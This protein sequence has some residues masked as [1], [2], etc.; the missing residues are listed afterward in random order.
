[1]RQRMGCIYKG[2]IHCKERDEYT[3]VSYTAKKGTIT[4]I[5][6]YHTLQRTERLHVYKCIIHCEERDDYMYIKVS[7]IAKN[8]MIIIRSNDKSTFLMRIIFVS[9]II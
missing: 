1:M 7:Y 4:C 2:I 6:R 8:W 5:Q 9:H 3:K